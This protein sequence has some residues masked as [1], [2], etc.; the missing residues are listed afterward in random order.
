MPPWSEWIERHFGEGA[1][2]GFYIGWGLGIVMGLLF[3]VGL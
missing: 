2:F 1:E 3:L